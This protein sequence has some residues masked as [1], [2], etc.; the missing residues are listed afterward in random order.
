MKNMKL[1]IKAGLLVLLSLVAV[2]FATGCNGEESPYATN[3]SEN[4]T[5]S[6]KYDANGGT[7]TTNTS[8]IVDSY[9]IDDLEE[10]SAGMV[11]IALISPD[12]S[13]RGNDAFTATKTGY[14]L[15]GWYA[16]R[17]ESAD[18]DGNT[19]YT[20]SDRWDFESG[21]LEVDPDKTYSSETPVLTLYAAW[22]PMFEIEFYSLDSGEYL[23]S[24]IYDP[25]TVTE[26]YVPEWDEEKGV[27]EMYHFPERAGYTFNKAYYDEN[28]SQLVDTAVVSHPG[29]VDYETGTAEN[30]VL[31]LYVDW[32]EGEWYRIY[33][34]EQFVD[35]ASVSGN[36]E[37]YAD[38][39]FS[40]EIWPTALMYGNFSGSIKGN[41]HVM[42]NIELSQTNNSKVNAGLFGYLTETAHITE[43]TFENVTFT[44]EKGTRVGGASFGILAGTISNAAVLNQVKLV[45]STLQIDSS[46]YFGTSDYSIGLICG[47]GDATVV[48]GTGLTCTAVGNAPETLNVTADG[49]TVTIADAAE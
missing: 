20:Y 2:I 6:V 39:D 3:D 47:M 25:T 37:I 31:K 4:Y 35:N 23:N 48:E 34:A 24:Y 14:F 33:T 18:A 30:T 46:S 12:D 27:I 7:F 42:K 49:N 16:D 32:T 8:V 15:A 9:N 45:D 10:N 44:I 19:V 28:G 41:G 40:D 29:A 13:S 38:L 36:Y 17:T 22:I 5:V 43:L 1:K 21:V 11:E 26:I